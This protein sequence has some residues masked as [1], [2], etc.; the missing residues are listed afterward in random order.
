MTKSEIEVYYACMEFCRAFFHLMCVK[1]ELNVHYQLYEP[2]E[3][4][5]LLE[6]EQRRTKHYFN[7]LCE[8]V[9]EVRND[10]SYLND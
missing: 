7:D 2:H 5:K 8:K 9:D 10:R 4:K 3:R 1:D 6:M